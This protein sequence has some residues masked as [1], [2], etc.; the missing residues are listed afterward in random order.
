MQYMRITKCSIYLNRAYQ[1]KPP[2]KLQKNI[3]PAGQEGST[4]EYSNEVKQP[5]AEDKK[6]SE[7]PELES[8]ENL[9]QHECEEANESPD[10]Q[11]QRNKVKVPTF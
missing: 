1:K 3:S 6:E 4:S 7:I 10:M 2:K 11:R 5:G 8:R 9:D